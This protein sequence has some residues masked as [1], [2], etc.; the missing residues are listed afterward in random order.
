MTNDEW[1]NIKPQESYSA[2]PY[3]VKPETTDYNIVIEYPQKILTNEQIRD[4][5]KRGL[6]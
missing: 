4:F 2:E 3:K 5:F 1:F 6:F